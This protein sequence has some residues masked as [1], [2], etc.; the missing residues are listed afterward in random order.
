[1]RHSLTL[2]NNKFDDVERIVNAF[3]AQKDDFL[4]DYAHI[5][6]M[7]RLTNHEI[8]DKLVKNGF[9]SGHGLKARMWKTALK[10]ALQT[11]DMYWEAT[12]TD[13]AGH[14]YRNDNFTDNEKQDAL[15]IISDLKNVQMLFNRDISHNYLLR[16]IRK[17]LGK[18]P[19]VQ[20]HRTAAY[21]QCM[22][23][24][25]VNNGTQY[26]SI[27]GLDKKR[28]K[29]PLKG[30]S[31]FSGNIR[32]VLNRDD[33]TADI[34]VPQDVKQEQADGDDEGIDWGVTEML[35]DNDG[36]RYYTDFGDDIKA[37][38]DDV[39][40]KGKNRNMLYALQK[41]KPKV[42]KNIKKYNLGKK[43]MNNR[44]RRFRAKFETKINTALNQFLDKKQPRRI[45][46]EDLSHYKP[47]VGKGCFSRQ[48]SFWVR[49][50]MN[51]RFEFKSMVGGSNPVSVN[52]A[53]GSQTCT[54]C[55]YVNR[56]NRNGDVFKCRSCGT[57][58]P[59]DHLAAKNYL[60]RLDDDE[61]KVWMKPHHVKA[62]LVR[63]FESRKA[64]VSGKTLETDIR[65]FTAVGQSK[66]E[67]LEVGTSAHF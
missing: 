50:I 11:I 39:N 62:I 33:K 27:M 47:P 60:A 66:S 15:S 7:D 23:R 57:M 63:R 17:S 3:A 20:L 32:I 44:N 36:D 6:Y 10:D 53:Y 37:Y 42:A 25:F 58:L 5:K 13:V 12:L 29:L 59:A 14:I 40:Q 51:D 9:V 8:R 2:N 67:T 61:I 19:R 28:I 21:D 38:A 30:K 16:R 64:T 35:T 34:H 56:L 45:A 43:K 41:N 18:R 24:V 46:K 31:K 65:E 1:M 26:I 55:G 49:S 54:D 22:Y 4:V 52:G 48:T